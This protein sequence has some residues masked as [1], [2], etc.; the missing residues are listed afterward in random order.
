I[1]A[2]WL[3]PDHTGKYRVE[4]VTAYTELFYPERD[5]AVT[6]DRSRYKTRRVVTADIEQAVTEKLELSVP[7]DCMIENKYLATLGPVGAPIGD[8]HIVLQIGIEADLEGAPTR[9]SYRA[10]IHGEAGVFGLAVEKHLAAAGAVRR[11]TIDR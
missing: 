3:I 10:S 11:S 8:N 2:A 4:V 7:A 5:G 9:A 6:F 1:P